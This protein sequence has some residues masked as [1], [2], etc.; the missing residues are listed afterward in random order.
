MDQG[1]AKKGSGQV[2]IPQDGHG[3]PIGDSL[4]RYC[5]IC[6][7][8]ANIHG[9][10]VERFGEAFCSEGHAEEFVKEVHAARV[11]AAAAALSAPEA[12]AE[13]PPSPVAPQA[14]R[15]PRDWKHYLKMG[16]CCGAPLLALLFLAGGGGAVLGAAGALLPL[17]AV[18]A[19]PVGMY[20]LM[21]SM[22]K[23]E[24]GG[25]ADDRDGRKPGDSPGR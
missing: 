3:V 22:A 9:S 24:H 19:C 7:E 10:R 18:L 11:Q 13:S 25:K 4:A 2:E 5:A 17:L 12:P 8:E 6:G 16:A 14:A 20:F 21:R 15:K 23:M 1:G